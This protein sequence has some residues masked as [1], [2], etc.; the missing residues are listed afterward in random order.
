MR[1]TM[2]SKLGYKAAFGGM[3]LGCFFLGNGLVYE[4][5]KFEFL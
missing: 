4:S 2:V 3:I 5:R 1:F